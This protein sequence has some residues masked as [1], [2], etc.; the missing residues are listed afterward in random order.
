[1][2]KCIE[3]NRI[4]ATQELKIETRMT[5]SISSEALMPFVA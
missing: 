1:M 4:D 5:T 3:N 2:K